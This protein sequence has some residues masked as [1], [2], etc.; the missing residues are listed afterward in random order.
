[1]NQEGRYPRRAFHPQGVFFAIDAAR[2]LSDFAELVDG[3]RISCHSGDIPCWQQD[4]PCHAA[5]FFFG[6]TQKKFQ[7]KHNF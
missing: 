7:E 5:L 3:Q 2:P 4:T 6:K 1:V